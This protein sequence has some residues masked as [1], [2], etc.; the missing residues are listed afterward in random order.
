[1]FTSTVGN[2]TAIAKFFELN[3]K[4][5]RWTERRFRWSSDK[6]FWADFESRVT[7]LASS[8]TPGMTLVD[9]GGGRRCVWYASVPDGVRVVT[10]DISQEELDA[11]E[12][13]NDKRLGDIAR[14]LPL[15]DGE[16]DSL[17]S[18]ALLEHVSDVP[19][20]VAEMAR[21][22][23]PGGRSLHLIPARNSLFGLA[24]RLGPF[25]QLKK[26]TH[27][28]IPTAKGQVEFPVVYD[29]CTARDL[30]HLFTANGFSKVKVDVCYS[31]SGYFH[32]VFPLYL[33]VALYQGIMSRLGLRQAAA[34][35]IVDALR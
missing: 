13:I 2:M 23:K 5:S 32:P 17:I 26:L 1:M 27:L 11:N 8:A 25:E 15:A 4:A 29:H 19:R 34:Y 35:L 16:A 10:V 12:T 21:V 20:A 14:H 9:V 28:A 22:Q 30:E 24:A 18:R 31:Q 3:T 7:E 33:L 6:P